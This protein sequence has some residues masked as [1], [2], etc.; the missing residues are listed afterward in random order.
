MKCLIAEKAYGS[1]R[2]RMSLASR[3]IEAC[4][5]PKSNAKNPGP[6]DRQLY[7]KRH[8]I[9]NLFAKLKDWKGI[10]FR[11]NRCAHS[12][13]SFVALAVVFIFFNAD[14]A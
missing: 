7:R 9:E 11:G 1:K 6:Y 12:F 13:R 8:V 10:A 5:P 14:R 2:Y 3:K 4:I